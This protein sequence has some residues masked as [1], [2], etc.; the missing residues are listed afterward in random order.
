[1]ANFDCQWQE[2]LDEEG[3]RCIVQIHPEYWDEPRPANQIHSLIEINPFIETENLSTRN[4]SWK[5]PLPEIQI[6]LKFFDYMLLIKIGFS[7]ASELMFIDMLP[8]SCLP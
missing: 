6:R 2:V 4:S 3:E 8:I 7:N 1:M 5:T